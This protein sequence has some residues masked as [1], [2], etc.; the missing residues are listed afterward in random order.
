MKR[1]MQGPDAPAH[2]RTSLGRRAVRWLWSCLRAC[3]SLYLTLGLITILVVMLALGTC[4]E[5]WHGEA[6]AKF[7]VYGAW[8]F[9]ALGALL[10]LNILA[11]LLI[12]LPWRRRLAGF[13]AA[14]LGLLVLLA[15]CLLSRQRGVEATLGIFEHRAAGRA[16]QDSAHFELLV[17]P[18]EA[19]ESLRSPQAE[20]PVPIAIPFHPGPFDWRQYAQLSWFPWKLVGHEQGWTYD[21]DGVRLEVLDYYADYQ[22]VPIPQLEL[23]PTTR[24]TARADS[25][26]GGLSL[27]GRPAPLELVVQG[28]AGG[29]HGMAGR[30]GLGARQGLPGGQQVCF[31]MTGS[32][33]E[34][35]AFLA[36]QPDGPLGTLGRVALAVRGQSFQWPVDGWK[37]GQR[38]PLGATGLEV[39]LVQEDSRFGRVRLAIHRSARD[40]KD[41]A[42]NK[43]GTVPVFAGTAAQPWLTKTGLSPSNSGSSSSAGSKDA[44][45]DNTESEPMALYADLPIFNQQDYRDGVYG[46]Y[47]RDTAPKAKNDAAGHA[48]LRDAGQPR[49]DILQ[50]ADQ[51]LYVRTWRAGKLEPPVPLPSDG[52]P[53]T[54]FAGTPDAVPLAVE[55]F[56]PAEKP[57]FLP[58]PLT[59]DQAREQKSMNLYPQQMARVRLTVDGISQEFWLA[60]TWTDPAEQEKSSG[61]D[62]SHT[63]SSPDRRVQLTLRQDVLDL[64]VDVRLRHFGRIRYAAQGARTRPRN[65]PAWSMCWIARRES[66]S[67]ARAN[68]FRTGKSP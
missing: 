29:P 26:H 18:A 1:V 7:A 50:G 53:W 65:T 13:V 41:R 35:A 5:N 12:R 23:R 10:G 67:S 3:G 45:A 33:E 27:E 63:V 48:A 54:A 38:K 34:T 47:W 17:L 9:V 8:W 31:W 4:L 28:A 68:R 36:D 44:A 20:P 58:M 24:G 57:D 11:A 37:A 25:P 66:R 42:K 19:R 62:V 32:R 21:R 56:V 2:R 46:T 55:R 30:Y 39:E 61:G 64:G 22:L 40:G 59:A 16:W 52:S 60:T 43:S 6:A 51:L 15:G 49:V 14:H